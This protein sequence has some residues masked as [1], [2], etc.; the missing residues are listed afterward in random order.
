MK[1][2]MF[3]RNTNG[4]LRSVAQLDEVRALQRRLTEEDAVVGDDADG[5]AVE[6]GEPGHQRGAVGPLELLEPAPVDQPRDDLAHVVLHPGVHRDD[7]VELVGVHGR[8]LDRAALPGRRIARRAGRHDLPDDAEGVDV[9]VREVVGDSRLLGVDVSAAQVLG[10][11]HLSGRRLH[12]RRTTQEDRALVADDHG[13]VAHR[14]HV[15][16]AGR[17]RAEHRGDLRDTQR[18]QPGLV[19]EDPAEVVAV[20]EDLVLHREEGA[21][22]V[23]EVDARQPVLQGHLLGAQVLLHGQREVGAALDGRVV[24]DDHA[25]ATGDASDPRDRAGS[26]GPRRRTARARQGATAPGTVSPGR[27]ARRL[28]RAGGACRVRRAWLARARDP[29]T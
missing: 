17:A 29:P 28:G 12:E 8:R 21:A 23:D 25:L 26:R 27:A 19:V 10:G 2:V 24:G 20:R 5:V 13:L 18:R 9:V 3:C 16:A 15:G 6:V 7:A 4:T 14:G 22:G 11:D 1:P